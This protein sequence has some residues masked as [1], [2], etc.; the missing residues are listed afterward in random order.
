[1]I[2]C[3]AVPTVFA[4]FLLCP[5]IWALFW[6]D[7]RLAYRPIGRNQRI[8]AQICLVGISIGVFAVQIKA[9]EYLNRGYLPPNIFDT[10]I[11][12]DWGGALLVLF[13][14]IL[15]ERARNRKL[16]NSRD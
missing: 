1:M 8:V 10:L 7:A 14:T 3:A 13:W 9:M 12:A 15:S 6:L 16:R 2:R 4:G 5:L 11:L